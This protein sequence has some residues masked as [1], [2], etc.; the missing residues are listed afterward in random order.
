MRYFLPFITLILCSSIVAIAESELQT[1][2]LWETAPHTTG[3]QSTDAPRLTA[4][5]ADPQTATGMSV[6][7]LPGGG[8]R[9]LSIKNEGHAIAQ[10]LQS[11]GI[12]AFVLEYRLPAD[13]YRH[14]IP[15]MDAQRAIRWLRSHASD[16]KLDPNRIGIIGF[17]AGGHLASSAAT[18]Y[19]SDVAIPEPSDAIDQ[20]SARPDFQILIYPVI[21]MDPEF[22]HSGSRNHLLGEQ[23]DQE[24]SQLMSSELQVRADAPPAFI[25]HTG[26]DTVVP[27]E[28]A[29]RYY[30]AL[31]Q[32]GVSAEL[33]IYP[34]GGH[35]FG[36]RPEA[37]RAATWTDLCEAWLKQ[38]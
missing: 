7:V 5:A 2:R 19:N 17:S 9:F 13:G 31:H 38:L 23:P 6:I 10:W 35:G 25:A 3:D 27:V 20:L 22:T 1:I 21:T 34:T 37:G 18:H 33:H 4:Y 12:S 36:A 14:P 11:I 15:L 30:R 28:N 26:D 32:A 8:Y 24:L 16:W 29:L